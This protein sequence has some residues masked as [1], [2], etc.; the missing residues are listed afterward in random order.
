MHGMEARAA[1]AV[2]L[3]STFRAGFQHHDRLPFRRVSMAR[4]RGGESKP[5]PSRI[6]ARNA[7]GMGQEP[8]AVSGVHARSSI[9]SVTSMYVERHWRGRTGA[10]ERGGP[11][12][13]EITTGRG[14]GD[15]K[16]DRRVSAVGARGWVWANGVALGMGSDARMGSMM[17]DRADMNRSL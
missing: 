10:G 8:G 5:A 13:K 3:Y 16:T 2:V 9:V 6:G 1:V 7:T 4:S 17:R 14:K 11:G 15:G 12:A